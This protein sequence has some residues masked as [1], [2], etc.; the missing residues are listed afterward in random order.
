MQA[1]PQPYI[2]SDSFAGDRW[3]SR[4]RITVRFCISAWFAAASLVVGSAQSL[5]Q[6]VSA[7]VKQYCVGCHSTGVKAGGLVLDTIVADSPIKHT[8]VWEKVIRRLRVRSMPPAGIPRPSEAGYD[9]LVS[10]L[11]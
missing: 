7:A 8:E 5:P 11:E 4:A 10:A 2:L 3:M 9:T 1:A 6:P